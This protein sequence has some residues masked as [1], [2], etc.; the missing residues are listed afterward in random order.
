MKTTTIPKKSNAC[1]AD[2]TGET[3][4]KYR[5]EYNCLSKMARFFPLGMQTFSIK[6]E[7]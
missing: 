5:N 7:N 2:E 1:K 3:K 4:V 6:Q